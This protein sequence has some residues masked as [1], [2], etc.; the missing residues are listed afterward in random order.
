MEPRRVVSSAYSLIVLA[1]VSVDQRGCVTAGGRCT[2]IGN[3]DFEGVGCAGGSQVLDG[4]GEVVWTPPG[5]VTKAFHARA[6]EH[7]LIAGHGERQHIGSV[8]VEAGA[9]EVILELTAQGAIGGAGD[10]ETEIAETAR[11][12]DPA[13]AGPLCGPSGRVRHGHRDWGRGRLVAGGISSDGCERV[14]AIRDSG[15]VPRC[16]IW[17][18]R[19]LGSIICAV[20]FELNAN[21]CHVVGSGGRSRNR[22]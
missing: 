5:T 7:S 17:R 1:D 2:W 6:G 3:L 21:H 10:K 12:V 15:R 4:R 14:R 16:R 19:I 22:A 20:E 13:A 8:K 18:G 9:V 11:D